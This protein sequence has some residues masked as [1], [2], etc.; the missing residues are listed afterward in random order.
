LNDLRESLLA[1]SIPGTM[2]VLYLVAAVI[3]GGLVWTKFAHVEE[4]T[5][6]QGKVI[7]ATWQQA[8]RIWMPPTFLN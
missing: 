3:V 8:R 1:Q 5:Q 4:V 6:G 7:P 2:A